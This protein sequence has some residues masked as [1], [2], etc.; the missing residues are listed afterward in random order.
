MYV[1]IHAPADRFYFIFLDAA[2]FD[3]RVDW[4][5]ADSYSGPGFSSMGRSRRIYEALLKVKQFQ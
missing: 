1:C 4:L 2:M 3:Y 5:D